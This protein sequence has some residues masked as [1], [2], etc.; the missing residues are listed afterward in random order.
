MS[1][2]VQRSTR[3]RRKGRVLVLLSGGVDSS[4]C[5]GYY[6]AKGFLIAALFVDYGQPAARPERA[7]AR[8]ICRHYSVPLRSVSIRGLKLPRSGYIP[9]R[10]ALL[11]ATALSCPPTAPASIALGIHDGTTYPDCGAIFH[12]AG[13][14]LA[15]IYSAGALRIVAPFL[16]WN[17]GQIIQ[18]A[19]SIRVP[20]SATYSCES[21][22]KPPCRRCSSCRDR[23]DLQ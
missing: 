10:N 16:D 17:K 6:R 1:E 22:R 7:A 14:R 20:L 19:T 2:G 5:I 13:Q 9:G 11:V 15:D 4:T 8:T 3:K 18:Y 23:S 21:G 12:D